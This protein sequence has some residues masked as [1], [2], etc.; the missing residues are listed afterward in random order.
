MPNLFKSEHKKTNQNDQ[1][2][3]IFLAISPFSLVNS[4]GG[5]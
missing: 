1:S 2:D 5:S 4:N 3:L